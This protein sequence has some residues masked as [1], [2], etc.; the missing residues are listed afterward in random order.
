M[1]N[2]APKHT[3]DNYNLAPYPPLAS[4]RKWMEHVIN[5]SISF[6]ELL[7]EE[8]QT[9]KTKWIDIKEAGNALGLDTFSLYLLDTNEVLTTRQFSD[10]L[11]FSERQILSILHSKEC[12]KIDQDCLEEVNV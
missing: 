2:L 8:W 11:K 7:S 4:G 1:S 5:E 3:N 10:E 12:R 6:T 9:L